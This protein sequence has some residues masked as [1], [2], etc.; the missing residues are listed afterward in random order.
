M[1]RILVGTRGSALATTQSQYV[2]DMLVEAGQ[3]A[4]LKTVTTTGDITSG[5]LAQLGGTGVFAAALRQELLGGA[6]DVAVHSLKDLPT[7]DLFEGKLSLVY[8]PRG[9]PRDVLVARDGL[10]LDDL[11]EGSSIGTGSPRRAA[12]IRVLRPDCS[13]TDIRGNVGTRLSRVAGLEH[14][15]TNDKGVG[16]GTHGDLDAVVLAASGLQRLGLEDVV[17]EYLD[18]TKVLPAP[19]QGCLAIEYRTWDTGE[20]LMTALAQ[21]DDAQARLTVEAERALLLRLEAGC[22]API[23][24]YAQV[25]GESLTL[26]VVVADPRGTETL[27][28]T[29]SA[30]VRDEDAAKALGTETAEALLDRG[31]AEFTELTLE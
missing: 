9:D 17:T 13:V 12:Q 5:P 1:T 24:A 21:I 23:G 6:V 19:G 22:A 2:A 31:A 14:Y 11:P 4:R 16:R 26:D 8:P 28:E 30:P 27:R 29:R 10:R 25:A 3:D 7:K 15:A 18:P 20:D